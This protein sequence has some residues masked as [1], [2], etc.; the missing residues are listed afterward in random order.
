MNDEDLLDEDLDA[1][2]AD[3]YDL[4]PDDSDELPPP[5][6]ADQTD[7]LLRRRAGIVRSIAR[8]E[9][10]AERRRAAITA[11]AK[12]RTAGLYTQLT[13]IDA[14]LEAWT[15]AIMPGRKTKTEKLSAGAVSLR[16]HT[17]VVR[18]LDSDKF[19]AWAKENGHLDGSRPFVKSETT[20]K[21]QLD[22]I[23]RL[24]AV[25]P[26]LEDV[27]IDGVIWERWQA[28]DPAT[29]EAIPDLEYRK[30]KLDTFTAKT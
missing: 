6:N 16:A 23:K 22:E 3:A 2:L 27:E 21:P 24:T 19:V 9:D 5:T 11:W 12:D 18:V 28:I 14:A 4:P 17:Q 7:L 1:Y 20:Y 25:G 15:R 26:Q 10:T 8:H 29:G 30:E 13:K